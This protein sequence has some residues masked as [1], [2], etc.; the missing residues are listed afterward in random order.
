MYLACQWAGE[1]S[2]A[3]A[4]WQVVQLAIAAARWALGRLWPLLRRLGA[5]GLLLLLAALALLAWVFRRA[6]RAGERARLRE[7]L[8]E[9]ER[10]QKQL[11]VALAKVAELEEAAAARDQPEPPGELAPKDLA[12][13][14]RGVAASL[15]DGETFSTELLP[16]EE[17][18]PA[19]AKV[20]SE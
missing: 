19:P 1:G 13:L 5:R 8:P 12:A 15:K 3:C 2:A 16:L 7:L 17:T 18:E 6:A 14:R 10:T 4:A 11:A 9:L 20:P